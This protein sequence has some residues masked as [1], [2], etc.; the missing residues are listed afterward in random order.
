M[1]ESRIEYE[2]L[3]IGSHPIE[4]KPYYSRIFAL[5]SRFVTNSGLLNIRSENID[6]V[7]YCRE[8]ESTPAIKIQFH[9]HMARCNT[10]N[11]LILLV[12]SNE[13]D[14]LLARCKPAT[15]GASLA[16]P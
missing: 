5:S 12:E 10:I 16:S 13:I 14:K 3:P 6:L 15:N 8:I 11:P 1:E 2:A 9:C 4:C 7:Q